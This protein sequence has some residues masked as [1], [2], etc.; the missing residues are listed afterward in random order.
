M[1][2]AASQVP[3]TGLANCCIRGAGPEPDV[4]PLPPP[5]LEYV[6]TVDTRPERLMV[7]MSA[8]TVPTTKV[9]EGCIDKETK[10]EDV[11]SME[12]GVLAPKACVQPVR[13][14]VP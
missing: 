14:D 13:L 10:F 11:P 8:E 7:K 5:L 1:G 3:V 12:T 6:A 4:A 2:C 9:I